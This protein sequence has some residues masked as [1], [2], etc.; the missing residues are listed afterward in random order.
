MAHIHRYSRINL[1][2]AG[3]EPVWVM[4]CNL[5][6]QCTHYVFMKTKI[7]CPA[8]RGKISICNKCGDEFSLD[9]RSLRMANPTCPS[10]VDSKEQ[11]AKV[12]AVNKLFASLGEEIK[13]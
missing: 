13:E 8:L 5:P 9:R 12:A 11:K 3:K 10:C 4:K 2:R 1:A 7:S 6:N